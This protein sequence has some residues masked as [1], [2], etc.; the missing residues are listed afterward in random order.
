MRLGVIAVD[1]LVELTEDPKPRV[2]H[3]A[4]HA[5]GKVGYDRAAIPVWLRLWDDPTVISKVAYTLGVFHERGAAPELASLL[6]REQP[7]VRTSA[8]VALQRL[9]PLALDSPSDALTS[10]DREGRKRAADI[11]ASIDDPRAAA[12]LIDGLTTMRGG[13]RVRP[14]GPVELRGPAHRGSDQTCGRGSGLASAGP[15]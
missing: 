7:E 6:T 9:G 1:P 14:D 2:R 4:I 3:D 12:A 11:L 8:A 15:R 10:G 13:T 5:L